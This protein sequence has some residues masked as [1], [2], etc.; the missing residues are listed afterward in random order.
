MMLSTLLQC[1]IVIVMQ[2][3]L[4]VVVVVVLGTALLFIKG[5]YHVF[6]CNKIRKK[7]IILLVRRKLTVGLPAYFVSNVCHVQWAIPQTYNEGSIFIIL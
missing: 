2:I 1:C 6:V 4:T 3:K 7:N 5:Y